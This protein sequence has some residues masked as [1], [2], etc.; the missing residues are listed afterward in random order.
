MPLLQTNLE[1]DYLPQCF[2]CTSDKP[3]SLLLLVFSEIQ[4]PLFTPVSSSLPVVML[5]CFNS[6]SALDLKSDWPE[7]LPSSVMRKREE[8]WGRDWLH[9]RQKQRQN[10]IAHAYGRIGRWWGHIYHTT[11]LP[12][13]ST[14]IL[15]FIYGKNKDKTPLR[16][17]TD[18]FADGGDTYIIPQACQDSPHVYYASSTAKTKTKR[19]CACVWT[20]LQMVGHIY[21]TTS[22]PRQSAFILSNTAFAILI[23]FFNWLSF[24]RMRRLGTYAATVTQTHAPSCSRS[25]Y[26]NPLFYTTIP[27]CFNNQSERAT[28]PQNRDYIEYHYLNNRFLC[29][30]L[31]IL[32]AHWFRV[33]INVPNYCCSKPIVRLNH[34]HTIL[35]WNICIA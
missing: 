9:L 22:L 18:V 30:P 17:R 25:F 7:L 20:C 33:Y 14:C 11:S 12:R 35:T 29:S 1:G 23:I 32:D 3:G 21:H 2:R 19:H 5:L 28:A 31:E 16:M 4:P 24:L 34:I 8:L 27:F 6:Q 15:R 10:A 13:Q 26:G